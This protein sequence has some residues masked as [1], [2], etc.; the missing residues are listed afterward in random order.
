WLPEEANSHAWPMAMGPGP[1]IK[2]RFRSVRLGIYRD[3]LSMLSRITLVL[4]LSKDG[5]SMLMV[6]QAHQERMRTPQSAALLNQIQEIVEQV[7]GVV[8]TWRRFRMI[9]HAEHRPFTVTQ[10][11]DSSVVQIQMRHL[12]IVG[13]RFRID[14]E[15]VILR[16]DF[17]LSSLQLLHRMVRA[18]VTE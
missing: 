5:P 8:R 14:R 17:D 3:T 7:I 16:R 12:D 11:F 13:Q 2:T 18:S 6:R 10:S 9:L 1:T 4:S 15:A